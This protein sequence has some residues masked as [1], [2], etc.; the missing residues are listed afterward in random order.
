MHKLINR[1]LAIALI[2]AGLLIGLAG[3]ITVGIAYFQ[4]FGKADCINAGGCNIDAQII[5]TRVGS[6]AFYSS[7][8]IVIA[9]V[10]DLILV[11]RRKQ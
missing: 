4:T 3:L 1:K 8:A 9:G 10:I 11:T 2:V 5:T 7:L 6:I